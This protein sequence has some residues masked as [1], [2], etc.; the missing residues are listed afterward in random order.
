MTIA[1]RAARRIK[2]QTVRTVFVADCCSACRQQHWAVNSSSSCSGCWWSDFRHDWAVSVF[3]FQVHNKLSNLCKNNNKDYKEDAQS[4]SSVLTRATL[5]Q[6]YSPPLTAVGS[7]LTRATLGVGYIPFTHRSRE[8]P[9][10]GHAQ[11]WVYSFHLPQSGV[12]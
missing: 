10:Q 8:C 4:H 12:P 11:C 6:G 7:A 2:L 9:D 3:S 5:G 1:G